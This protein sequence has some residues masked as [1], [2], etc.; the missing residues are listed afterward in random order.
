MSDS[1]PTSWLNPKFKT[2][3]TPE[4]LCKLM[5][6]RL[7]G[8]KQAMEHFYNKFKIKAEEGARRGDHSYALEITDAECGTTSDFDVKMLLDDLHAL[9]KREGFISVKKEFSG[10][11]AS[12]EMAWKAE[13]KATRKQAEEEKRQLSTVPIQGGHQMNPAI[14]QE[15]AA[16][17]QQFVAGNAANNQFYQV[18][19]Y[20]W[21][22]WVEGY[23]YAEAG[24][25]SS[26]NP[27]ATDE[28]E[29]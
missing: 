28:E 11:M 17:Y 12:L 5:P 24:G 13:P 18:Q 7:V 19:P 22:G 6:D 14:M 25:F 9:L 23:P 16:R 21:G 29:K 1:Q 27:N 26:P 2:A 20:P 3:T 15:L 4:Y 8:Q 10:E